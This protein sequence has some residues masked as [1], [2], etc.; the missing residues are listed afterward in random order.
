MTAPADEF[1]D[2]GIVMF[3][4][5]TEEDIESQVSVQQELQQSLSWSRSATLLLISEY[6]SRQSQI[7]AGKK[8]KNKAF[9]EISETLK[10]HGY[11]FNHEQCASRLKT[12]T[13]AY[14]NMK[15]HNSKSGNSRK[16]YEYEQEL[17]DLYEKRPNINPKFVLSTSTTSTQPKDDD[18]GNR[19]ETEVAHNKRPSSTDSE[20]EGNYTKPSAPKSR[21][22]QVSEVITFIQDMTKNQEERHKNEQMK[23]EERHKDKMSVFKDLIDVLKE[24]K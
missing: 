6:K 10:E 19:E 14:K 20:T 7:E 1:A 3:E 21:K 18:P 2:A 13:R 5:S 4:N 8:R 16:S 11:H 12:I 9:T 22:T 17:N 15:D 23:K 24:K